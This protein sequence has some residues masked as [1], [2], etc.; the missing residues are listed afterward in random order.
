MNLKA[1][2]RN[3]AGNTITFDGL[4]NQPNQYFVGENTLTQLD[5][6]GNKI[7]GNLASNY[8]LQKQ[9]TSSPAMQAT[10]AAIE[11]TE[12][13]WKLV[14]LRGKTIEEPKEGEKEVFITFKKQESRVNGYAGCNNFNGKY[15][16]KEGNQI[17]FSAIAS[18]LK[19]CPDMSIE[20]ELT[21]VLQQ[22][23]NYAISE[24]N[25]LSI[26]QE[27]RHSPDLRLLH[28]NKN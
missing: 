7:T 2:L 16:A 1:I 18:T 20:D 27:W 13:Y 10:S 15:E 19:A 23:D 12:T 6:N 22:V 25:F 8:I 26:K 17:K 14:E 9:Q 3:E 21:K 24:I 11:L 5:M 4:Q 28:L